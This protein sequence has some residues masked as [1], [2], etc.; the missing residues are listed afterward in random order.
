MGIRGWR[1]AGCG[2]RRGGFSPRPGR[3]ALTRR[4]WTWW[5]REQYPP[6]IVFVSAAITTIIFDRLR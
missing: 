3:P 2:I 6:W 1:R 4:A 5:T